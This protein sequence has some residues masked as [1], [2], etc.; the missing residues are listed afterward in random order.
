MITVSIVSHG[1]GGV[2]APAVIDPEMVIEDSIRYFSAPSDMML[3]N[4]RQVQSKRVVSWR[5]ILR[6]LEKGLGK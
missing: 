5:V 4:R 1:H 6:V 2:V 3:K